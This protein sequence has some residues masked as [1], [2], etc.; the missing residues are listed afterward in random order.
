ML[1]NQ[2]PATILAAGIAFGLIGTGA[3]I[4][5]AVTANRSAERYV[6]VRGLAEKDVRADLV[7]WPIKVRAAGNRLDEV[8]AAADRARD[9]VAAFL[10]R[11]GLPPEAI[12]SQHIRVRDRLAN[13]YTSNTNAL[14]YIV[15]YTLQLRSR[16]VDTIG[17][18]SRMTDELVAAGVVLSSDGAWNGNNP[19]FLFTGLNRI[20]PAMMADATR[21]ARQAAQQFAADSG[22]TL[23]R[24]RRASQGLFTIADRDRTALHDAENASGNWAS[25]PDKRVR[26]VVSVDYCLQ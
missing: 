23:G 8:K 3:L 15:E 10:N 7:V 2:A 12:A 17:R 1:N 16:D 20:K 19:Q 24:I 9:E 4:H 25:E 6:T 5:H 11:H 21:A 26:V 14:R 22:S 18:V 13:D